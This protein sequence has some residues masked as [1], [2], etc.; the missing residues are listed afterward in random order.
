MANL[1][2]YYRVSTQK[3]GASGLGLEAQRATV[4]DYAK[5][6]GGAI[7]AEFTEVESGKKNSRVELARAIA[8]AK[9]LGAVLV[10]AKLDRL[11]RNAAFIFTLRDSGVSFVACDVPEANTLTVGVMAVMAQ[12][13]AELISLRTR[14]ALAAKKQRGAKLGTPANLTKEARIKGREAH[15][16]N[17][18]NNPNTKTAKGY[19]AL[20][21]GN[22]ASLRQMAQTLNAEGFKTPRGGKFSAVQVARLLA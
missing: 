4:E 16:R 5:R 10:I 22:G 8:E 15:S 7:V 17:A 19:A 18:A 2:S 11:A 9:R 20:L 13:E 21:R 6:T 12:H 14:A 1:I 3:Q